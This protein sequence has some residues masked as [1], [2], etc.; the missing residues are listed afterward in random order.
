MHTICDV[1][2]ALLESRCILTSNGI[3]E[4]TQLIQRICIDLTR[5]PQNLFDLTDDELSRSYRKLANYLD[6]D[7]VFEKLAAHPKMNRYLEQMLGPDYVHFQNMAL[8]KPAK[9]GSEKPWHQDNAYFNVTPLDAIIGV[10]IA[11]DDATVENGCMHVIPTARKDLHA[12]KHIHRSDCEIDAN[13][14]DISKVTPVEVPAGGALLFFGMLPHQTPP[15]RSD[16]GRRALQLHY[17]GAEC[18]RL[19]KPEYD[20]V[21]QTPD[22][23]PASCA[24][25]SEK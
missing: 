11:I 23:R 22:G 17:H 2:D 20:K 13:D 19:D 6:K 18:V 8:S 16:K 3:D 14:L 10:W 7:P 12:F 15:N 24:A 1:I 5:V 21:F 9:F 4:N 25:G